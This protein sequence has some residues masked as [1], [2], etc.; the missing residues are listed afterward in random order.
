MRKIAYSL[1]GV[2]MLPVVL[3]LLPAEKQAVLRELGQRVTDSDAV[4]CLDYERKSLKDPDSAQLLTSSKGVWSPD[5]VG[6][7]YKARNSYGAFVQK[8]AA[9][10]IKSGQVAVAETEYRRAMDRI[11][12]QANALDEKLSRLKGDER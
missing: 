9:C 3:F 1:G 5:S 4:Q 2:A 12:A 10:E 6:I 8:D 7:V 11:N